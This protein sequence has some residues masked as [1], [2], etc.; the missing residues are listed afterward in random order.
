MT[1]P[2]SRFKIKQ[3]VWLD[4]IA[5]GLER[6]KCYDNGLLVPSQ[7]LQKEG[8]VANPTKVQLKSFFLLKAAFLSTLNPISF[9]PDSKI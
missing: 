5:Q 4:Y 1:L 8:N 3:E 9:Q 2:H 7:E 6:K